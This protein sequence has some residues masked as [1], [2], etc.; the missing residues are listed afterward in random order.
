[1]STIFQTVLIISIISAVLAIILTIADRK[2]ADYG[3]VSLM[4]NEEEP[5]TIEGGEN[6]LTSLRNQKIFI[7]SAC[8]GKGSCGYCKVRVVEGGGP[9]LATELPH[10]SEEDKK[11]NVRLSCQIKV[12]QDIHIEIPEELF[13]VREYDAVVEK[14]T[15]VSPRVKRVRFKLPEGEHIDFKPGQYIQIKAPLYEGSE[16]D[17]EVFRAYSIASSA[18]DK[19]AV[20]LFVGF[21]GGIATTYVHKHLKEGDIVNLNGP[22]G[23]FYYKD[24]DMGPML[25]I[26]TGTG[27]AP[28]LS[29][30]YHMRDN[31]IKRQARFFFGSK[32][33][34]DLFILDELA[35]LED[36]LYDFKFMPTLS[37][38]EEGMGWTGDTGRVND[39][40]MKYVPDGE[41]AKY[42]A[43]LCGADRMI[44]SAVEAL[45]SKGMPEDQIY[46]DKF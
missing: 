38:V 4:I 39:S 41:G 21:T 29:I 10:L 6:L 13:N 20:E 2:I 30:L 8:G 22:Y 40:I 24:D 25:M 28:I 15:D 31:D 18:R 19:G 26:A 9:V 12:K 32:T 36:E 44:D 35:E 11:T 14:I 3:Q 7:P 37:R 17:E 42:T 43:Y 23:D 33:P 5:I 1:M 45:T 46:Y 27:M 34:E 16:A